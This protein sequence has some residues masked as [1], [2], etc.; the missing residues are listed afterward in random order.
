MRGRTPQVRQP[1]T[2]FRRTRRGVHTEVEAEPR[3]PP[4]CGDAGP[5]PLGEG[6]H[7]AHGR[8]YGQ[9]T[10]LVVTTRFHG[11]GGT[12]R[13]ST[14][15]Q[16]T[17]FSSLFKPAEA[18]AVAHGGR[19]VHAG[20]VGEAAP[21][22][23]VARAEHVRGVVVDVWAA[24]LPLRVA[25]AP[26]TDDLHPAVLQQAERSTGSSRRRELRRV[27]GGPW[28]NRR[29]VGTRVS[30][31]VEVV[32]RQVEVEGILPRH[33]AGREPA[34]GGPPLRRVVHA[35][36]MGEPLVV[37]RGQGVVL[38]RPVALRLPD[39]EHRRGD[40]MVQR[41]GSGGASHR[42]EKRRQH[43]SEGRQQRHLSARRPGPCSAAA[44]CWIVVS[45]C[46]SNR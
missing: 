44:N 12:A 19:D 33:E 10:C 30:A 22:P 27:G 28:D 6:R 37:P 43:E 7:R 13:A 8:Y 3:P 41:V 24:V 23:P 26:P 14:N 45:V 32:V 11:P 42:S 15:C 16:S 20:V 39:P 21:R 29:P 25:D 1:C 36:V 46:T 31:V 34:V 5:A 18:E 17:A 9:Y 40:A 4:A 38:A 2:P 35:A